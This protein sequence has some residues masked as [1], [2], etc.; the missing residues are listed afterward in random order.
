MTGNLSESLAFDVRGLNKVYPSF[1]LGPLDLQLPSGRVLALVG[2]NGAGKTTLLNCMIGLCRGDRGQVEIFGERND[3]NETRW[4]HSVGYVGERHGFYQAWTGQANLDFL[5]GFYPSWSME[6]C[7]GLAQQLDLPL[8]KPVRDL[9]KG[10]SAKLALLAALGH[11]PRLLLLDEPFSSLDPLVR[12]S[13]HDILWQFL[14]DGMPAIMYSTHILSDVSRLADE[15]VF[16]ANGQVQLRTDTSELTD[17]WRRISFRSPSLID[18]VAST[19]DLRRE[20]EAY[21]LL[22]TDGDTTRKSLE[23]FGITDVEVTRLS[24]EEIAV[25][26]MRGGNDVASV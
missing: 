26:I 23:G 2:P 1:Q 18:D 3:P 24:L 14:D 22:S 17:S 12:A 20:G 10:N 19:F 4:K 15:I 13:V 9:S 16:I 5:A 25:E 21:W 11:G 6:L 8:D 7:L